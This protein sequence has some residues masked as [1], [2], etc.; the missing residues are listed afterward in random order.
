MAFN[1]SKVL[2][3]NYQALKIVFDYKNG[4]IDKLTD[5]QNETL[6][7]YAGFGGIKE[8]LYPIN[9][10][11]S[12]EPSDQKYFDKIVYK[13]KNQRLFSSNSQTSSH[14]LVI[15]NWTFGVS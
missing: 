9:D 14:L 7:K 13:V 11:S 15:D 10:K 5:E 2:E 3:N 8:I 1:K 4:K 6:K 12:W